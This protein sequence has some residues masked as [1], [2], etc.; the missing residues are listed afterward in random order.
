VNVG[1]TIT[2]RWRDCVAVSTLHGVQ[3]DQTDT[4]QLTTVPS[5]GAGVGTTDAVVGEDVGA[6]VVVVPA[7]HCVCITRDGHGAPL[8]CGSTVTTRVLART[9]NSTFIHMMGLQGDHAPQV[10][11]SQSTVHPLCSTRV[12]GTPSFFGD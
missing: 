12:Q 1:D 7:G 8:L 5:V 10:E 9:W 6:T 2:L 11:T 3:D 4:T